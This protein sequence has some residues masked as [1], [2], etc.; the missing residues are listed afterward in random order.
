VYCTQETIV[1]A[2]YQPIK[3]I[4]LEKRHRNGVTFLEVVD[5]EFDVESSSS[6]SSLPSPSE[7]PRSSPEG[8]G[9]GSK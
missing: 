4:V 9:V 5:I 1:L 2:A 3:R 7:N 8:H 6:S